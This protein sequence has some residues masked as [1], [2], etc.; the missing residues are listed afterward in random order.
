MGVVGYLVG[1]LGVLY[2]LLNIL[3]GLVQIKL[4]QIDFWASIAMMVGGSLIALAVITTAAGLHVLLAG[5]IVIHIVT[6]NNG[7]K[8][9]G[10]LNP[11]HHL[12]RLAFSILL[13]ALYL[14]K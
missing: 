13:V 14:F 12:I 4:K 8:L 11:K 1:I 9:H 5:L 6:M 7:V 10:K 3:A 2:G